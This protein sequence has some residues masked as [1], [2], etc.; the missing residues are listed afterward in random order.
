VTGAELHP[1]PA[2][3]HAAPAPVRHSDFTT[4][5]PPEEE[6]DD[7]PILRTSE[8]PAPPRGGTPEPD[9]AP[10]GR[11]PPIRSL[12]SSGKERAAEDDFVELYLN[13]GRREGVRAADLQRI[14]LERA[15]L[16]K[17]SIRRIRVRERNAFL[18]VRKTEVERAIAGLSGVSM[19]G[20]AIVAEQA[21]G[22]GATLGDA[23]DTSGP[24]DG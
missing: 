2:P 14:L 5:Q 18:G 16:A 12:E 9:L 22:R 3:R 6:G 21:R 4:W 24:D 20:R 7:E 15:G 19:G 13:V 8:P 17:E 23:D 11:E 10:P 1:A